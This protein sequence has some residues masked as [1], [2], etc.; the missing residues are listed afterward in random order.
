MGRSSTVSKWDGRHSL[1]GLLSLWMALGGAAC[2]PPETERSATIE[3]FSWWTE[4]GEEEALEQLLALYTS[5]H[6]GVE[7]INAVTSEATA[8]R[9]V[10]DARFAQG[11][12]PDTFQAN[13]GYDLT[14]WVVDTGATVG[15]SKIEDLTWFFQEED[16][17]SRIPA[18]VIEAV[19]YQGSP[20]AVPLNIHRNNSLF[21]NRA[22]LESNGL[23]PP[24]SFAELL[25]ACET[26]RVNAGIPCLAAG[27]EDAWALEL[28][29]WENILVASAGAEYYERFF[30]GRADPLDA[31]LEAS[32]ENL[33]ALWE[34]TPPDVM[35]TG[36]VDA[37]I[38]VGDGQAAFNVMGDWAKAVLQQRGKIAD[39]DFGQVAFPGTTGTFVFVTDTF[40]LALGGPARDATVDLLRVVASPEGQEVFNV[41]KGSIPALLDASTEDFDPLGQRT[42][43]EF[44]QANAWIM[45]NVAPVD[46]DMGGYIQSTVIHEK[47]EYVLNAIRNF[48]D[49]IRKANR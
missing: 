28:L 26:L 40:P 27:G 4:A 3:L 30:S 32:A 1:P 18:P 16:L 34:Y 7:V 10:L 20:Y 22:V 23:T 19:S 6:P 5:Q 29:F 49:I 41:V 15:Q 37:I 11:N 38:Q 31:E 25:A 2:T 12:P 36:W 35:A 17:F 14:R 33:L 21:Y 45:G 13:G 24:S 43:N 9:A 44:G 46:F 47:P 42:F 8:A 39:V 48:Y